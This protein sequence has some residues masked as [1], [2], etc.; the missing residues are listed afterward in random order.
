MEF[1]CDVEAIR[2]GTVVFPN[3]PL[4]RVKGPILQCQLIESALLNIINFQTLIATK[5]AR[6]NLAAKGESVM[7]F[8]LRRAQGIDGAISATRAAFIG[9]CSGTSNVLAAYQLGIPALGTHAHSWVQAFEDE[10]VAFD[11]FAEALP[12][13]T[14]FLVDTYN[15][16]KGIDHAIAAAKKAEA[17]GHRINGIRLDSGDLAYLSQLARKK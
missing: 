9:G 4:I 8:G 15:T 7:E 6:I 10:S 2:E 1:D 11:A 3:E 14:I 13:N 5:S 16:P 17:L 12:N